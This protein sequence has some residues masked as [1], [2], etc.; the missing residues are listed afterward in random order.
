[1]GKEGATPNNLNP[2]LSSLTLQ[3]TIEISCRADVS[4]NELGWLK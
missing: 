3:L 4:T 2:K 1:M